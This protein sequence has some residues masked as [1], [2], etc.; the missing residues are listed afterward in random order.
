LST[1]VPDRGRQSYRHEALLW[2]GRAEFVQGLVP[3]VSDG[4]AAGEAVM[5]AL[6]REHA[7]WVRDGLG[8][9]AS[10]VQFVDMAKL[11]KNPARIIP[12]WQEFLRRHSGDGRP[13][14]GIGEPIWAGRRPEEVLECQL[15]EALLNLAVDPEIPFWLVCPYDEEHLDQSILAEAHRSHPAITSRSSYQGSPAYGGHPHADAIFTAELLPIPDLPAEF[16]ATAVKVHD[17]FAF[18]A[19]QAAI[20]GLWSNTV[21]NLADVVR[22]LTLGSLKRGADRVVVRVWDQPHV[23]ICEVSDTTVMNDHL[24]GR[25][26]PDAE[27]SDPLWWANSV[28][29][30]VQTRSSAAGTTIRLHTWK[31]P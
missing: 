9:Q 22:G 11:G 30:L 27:Q 5:V 2:R 21:V 10:K 7:D 13:A 14:R 6:V 20:A 12:A 19:T 31:Q 1:S 17:V 15:H 23:L 18:V 26:A 16:T 8:R 25:R 4:L 29:D 28:C 24:A 3:F